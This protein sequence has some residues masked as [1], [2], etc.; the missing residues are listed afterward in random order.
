MKI[1]CISIY[2][3]NYDF[4]K[5]NNLVPVGLGNQNFNSNWLNDKGKINIYNKNENFGEYTFHYSLW[6]NGSL[7]KEDDNWT[8]F[9]TYRRF[10]IK[11]DF[12]IPKKIDD[13]NSTI[14]KEV[15]EDWKDFDTILAQ[16]LR[17]G[18]QKIMKL[19]KNNMIYTLKN[20]KLFF[21]ECT[22]EDHFNLYHGSYF[23]NEAIQLLDTNIKKD[24]KIFLKNYEFN[25]HNLFICKKHSLIK[26]YYEDIFK[27]LFNCEEKFKHFKLDS[28]R[29]KR[30][31]GFLAERY[32]PF[33]FKKN[34]KTLDWPYIFFDTNKLR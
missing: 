23:L 13:L 22:I 11:K 31:Y 32:L 24:F 30:I 5:K 20:P 21:R 1:Y 28:F 26:Q 9:C 8:G 12:E 14:L 10:W 17:L 19:F 34:S 2:N 16:P 15:P 3:E 33:W 7:D 27:W 29:K 4:F 25:P 6:K 18:K